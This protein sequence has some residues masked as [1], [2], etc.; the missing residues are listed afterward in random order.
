MLG[1][2]TSAIALLVASGCGGESPADVSYGA[3]DAG[4]PDS[5]IGASC[6]P[7]EKPMPDGACLPAGIQDDGCPAGQVAL[8]GGGCRPAGV[9]PGGCARGFVEDPA[10]GCAPILPAA[11]CPKGSMA[12]PGDTE[13]RPVAPCGSGPWGDIPIEPSTQFVDTAYAGGASDGTQANPWVTIQ[14]GVDAADPDAVVAV[15]PGS[16]QEIVWIEGKPVRLWGKCPAEVEVVGYDDGLGAIVVIEGAA[17]GT[18]IH[19][20]AARGAGSGITSAGAA[21]VLLERVWLHET[22]RAGLHV[23]YAPSA[24]GDTTARGILVED[25]TDYGVTVLA[26]TLELEGSH[27]RSAVPVTTFQTGI[28]AA[29]KTGAPSH[30]LVRS[31]LIE[32]H[33]LAGVTASQSDVELDATVVR[34]VEAAPSSNGQGMGVLVE[35]D[36]NDPRPSATG[37]IRSS[38]LSDNA[39][40]GVTAYGASL[41]VESTTIRGTILNAPFSNGVAA[42]TFDEG[43][44]RATLEMRSS[45]VDAAGCHG[46][47]TQA[48]DVEIQ[49]SWIGGTTECGP[50]QEGV[51]DF[52]HEIDA[53]H[54]PDTGDPS[55]LTMRSS[56]IGRTSELGVLVLGSD[57]VLEGVLVTG[58][59]TFPSLMAGG[60]LAAQPNASTGR[61]ATATIRA[62]VFEAAEGTAILA[63]GSAVT[64]ESCVVRDTRPR[65]LDQWFGRGIVTQHEPITGAAA[66]LTMRWSVVE[67]SREA[68]VW[69]LGADVVMEGSIVRDT[70]PL[71]VDGRFG[72]GLS[73]LGD[74]QRRSVAT[75]TGSLVERSVEIGIVCATSDMTVTGTTVRD[76]L[77]SAANGAFGDGIGVL[78]IEGPATASIGSSSVERSARAG[79]S[80]FG[81]AVSVGSTTLTCNAIDLDGEATSFATYV[82][83]DLGQNV[84]SCEEVRPCKVLSTNITPPEPVDPL[85]EP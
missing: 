31:S 39:T 37:T 73:I 7:G 47:I 70:E 1:R 11:K 51:Q 30:V 15:A 6:P 8:E 82:F 28:W 40:S 62:S 57:A 55:I 68:G 67:R 63:A 48:A 52:A 76:T 44:A 81:A 45:V 53:F 43:G 29:H 79:I 77:P 42:L 74:A 35:D 66:S 22:G 24:R 14:E 12:I 16:Y 20:L 38:V 23:Q 26:S 78:A 5:S 21:G 65:A 36:G 13:C 64:L 19:D 32:D 75:I 9:P 34:D 33:R 84:C 50:T 49:A 71:V 59:E 58:L 83:D 25:T 69:V 72:H 17:S 41:V 18:E 61:Q 4:G 3:T 2:L 60:G 27:V 56:V 46:V 10:G 80:S 85:D 54:H